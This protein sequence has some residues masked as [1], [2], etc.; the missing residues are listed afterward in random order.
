MSSQPPNLSGLTT[1]LDQT[2]DKIELFPIKAKGAVTRRT[3]PG[4]DQIE[5]VYHKAL[6]QG[7]FTESSIADAMF[8]IKAKKLDLE[9]K[10]TQYLDLHKIAVD[11]QLRHIPRTIKFIADAL[12][13][14]D[15]VSKYVS[16]IASLV[17]S[18]QNCIGQLQS[19]EQNMLAMVQANLNALANL[20]AE[21]CNWGLPDLPALP[22]LFSDSIWRFNGFNF[23][24][25]GSFLPHVGFDTNFSF[26]QCKLIV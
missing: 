11:G 20:L 19:I 14:V 4:I 10:I 17:G 1:A 21:V 16:S 12:T 18:L 23:F 2:L 6:E 24:P 5:G 9:E 26:N 8:A 25:L 22:N 7:R 3:S 13:I 15:R